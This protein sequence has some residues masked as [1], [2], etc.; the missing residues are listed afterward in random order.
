MVLKKPW[1]NEKED[2]MAQRW[3]LHSIIMPTGR[4]RRPRRRRG[5]KGGIL[6]LFLIPLL[7]AGAKA[8]ATGAVSG[9][10]GYGVKKALEK[11]RPYKGFFGLHKDPY[12]LNQLKKKKR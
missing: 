3:Y 10:A 1:R 9:V 6:P 11:R 12:I 2:K 7:A 5:Q 8:A 4:R